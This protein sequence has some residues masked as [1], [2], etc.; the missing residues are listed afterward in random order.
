MRW[1]GSILFCAMLV[2][3]SACAPTV[4]AGQLD[5]ERITWQSPTLGAEISGRVLQPV[6]GRVDQP[7]PTV[8]Y[9]AN[10]SIPRLG[11][12]GD[13]AIIEDLRRGGHLVLVLNYS[14][15][16][17]AKSPNLH[18][19]LLKLR[20][21]ITDAK[22]KNL[23]TE[24]RVDVNRLY[25]IPE[26]FRLRR[27]VEFARDGQRVLAMDVI[28]PANPENP[29]PAVFE[30]S[31]DNA[32]RMG[33]FS[34]LFC[35]DTLVEGAA[36]AGFAS[37]MADHPVAPPYKGLDDP[38]PEALK[39]AQSAASKL[40]SLREE[41]PLTGKVGA[42]GFS[43]G[44]PFAAMLAATGTVD[45][46]LVH[47]NRYDYLALR[48]DDPMLA[49]FSR[50]WGSVEA[51]PDRWAVHGAVHYLPADARGVAPMFL[52]TSNTESPEYRDGLAKLAQRLAALGVEHVYKVDED[53]RGHRVSTDSRTLAE[54]YAFFAK[55]LSG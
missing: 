14:R 45:A 52:N 37:A 53:G 8:V 29:V 10:L 47:G 41:L 32:N 39:R 38:M 15:N 25:I 6:E 1:R 7:L 54:I 24:H 46:A 43:R 19:D 34:L 31:C 26:G 51:N 49:R 33:S 48:G 22:Q 18:A 35:R 17:L 16:P 5:G 55:H 28:Y 12:D 30:F 40:K 42:M 20:Q 44:G 23:L 27:D 11:R 3:T 36:L 50:A 2:L 4:D 21:D 9:L 13:D